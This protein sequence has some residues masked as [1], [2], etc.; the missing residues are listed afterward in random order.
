MTQITNLVLDTNPELTVNGTATLQQYGDL[1]LFYHK[2]YDLLLV[3]KGVQGT[4]NL[5]LTAAASTTIQLGFIQ[6]KIEDI[7]YITPTD[8]DQQQYDNMGGK[9]ELWDGDTNRPWYDLYP[10]KIANLNHTSTVNMIDEPPA[11]LG[12]L[13]YGGY[14]YRKA[15]F[16]TC[17]AARVKPQHR[18]WSDLAR[19]CGWEWTVT[20]HAYLTLRDRNL[21]GIG[22]LLLNE[23]RSRSTVKINDS[24]TNDLPK[25]D[26]TAANDV[27]PINFEVRGTGSKKVKCCSLM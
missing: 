17:V 14:I 6:S 10:E 23:K 12:P 1:S 22:R 25:I 3:G 16:R 8:F 15:K 9:D 19:I 20:T 27:E 26:G 21:V 2:E 18:E 4:T 11:G 5:N 24:T 13:L 7:S